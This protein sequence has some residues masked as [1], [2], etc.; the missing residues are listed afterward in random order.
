[1]SQHR[2]EFLIQASA[3]PEQIADFVASFATGNPEPLDLQLDNCGTFEKHFDMYPQRNPRVSNHWLKNTNKDVVARF[4]PERNA[5]MEFESKVNYDNTKRFVRVHAGSLSI[6]GE[7]D[8]PEGDPFVKDFQTI[9]SQRINRWFELRQ[10]TKPKARK[11]PDYKTGIVKVLT[12]II[13][14]GPDNRTW[15]QVRQEQL[16]NTTYPTRRS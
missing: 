9:Q 7:L 3:N 13:P 4:T 8:L 11:Q 2:N 12:K 16:R 14:S 5:S 10:M 6:I 1:M 15:E